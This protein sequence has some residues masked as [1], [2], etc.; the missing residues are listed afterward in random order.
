VARN[1]HAG[2]S[3]LAFED[4]LDQFSA[5]A[6][7]VAGAFLFSFIAHPVTRTWFHGNPVFNFCAKGRPSFPRYFAVIT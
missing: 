4:R 3:E 6:T 1:A 5:P 7:S 2:L